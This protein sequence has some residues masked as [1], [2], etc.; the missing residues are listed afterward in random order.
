MVWTFEEIRKLR[1]NSNRFHSATHDEIKEGLT[2]DIYFIKTIEVLKHLGLESVNVVADIFPRRAGVLAGVEEVLKLL[3][4]KKN[5]KVWS[6][7][8]GEEFEK[9]EVI[10]Q[11]EGPYC[12][13]GPL[14]TVILGMLASASGWASAARECKKAAGGKIVLCFGARHVHP[15]VAPVMER[16]AIIG[17]ADAASCILG[18]KLLGKEPRGTIPHAA[19]LIAGDTVVFAKGYDEVMPEDEPRI[20][21]VD[22]FKDEAEEALR[23]ASVLKERLAGIRL[24]TPDE[25]GGVTSELIKEVR[26]RLDQAGFSHVK[27]FVSGGLTPE[28]IAFLKDA[29]VDGFGVGSYIVHGVYID[30][31]MDI[32]EVMGKP[33]AKRGR[34]PG[35]ANNPRL[36]RML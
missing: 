5:I 6:L 27:I 17:G 31:T 2:T 20:V 12:E 34:I 7:Q 1:V 36:K 28:R 11:I 15:A 33:I 26:A 14:E 19:I 16:A 22:T 23:V 4:D 3:E 35:R 25:R 30:M 10:M 9:K 29:P 32:K 13:F 18:A 24:D 8:E 21:L